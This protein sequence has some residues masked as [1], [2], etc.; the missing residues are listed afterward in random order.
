MWRSNLTSDGGDRTL[1]LLLL[2]LT[3]STTADAKI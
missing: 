3:T 1:R 2:L